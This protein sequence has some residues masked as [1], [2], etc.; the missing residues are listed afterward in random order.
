MDVAYFGLRERPF[1]SAADSRFIFLGA[2]QEKALAQ[3]LQGV[4]ERGGL[5]HLTG[6]AGLGKTTLCR[7]LLSRLPIGVDV[8]LVLNPVHSAED[9]LRAI[10]DE[11]G[12]LPAD[13]APA[14][15]DLAEV[16][17][18]HVLA[19]Q[20]N[21]RRVVLVVDDAQDL[22][23]G[24]LEELRRLTTLAA[25]TERLLQI[26]LIGRPELLELL[27]RSELQR[28]D[29]PAT[30][31]YDLLP[32]TERET[33]AYLRHRLTEAGGASE[34]FEREALAELHLRSGG[35]PRSINVLAERALHVAR[36]HGRRAVDRSMV[37]AAAKG[38]PVA[39]SPKPVVPAALPVRPG[40][41]ARTPARSSG[42]RALSPWL[43][44]A[45][46]V[47]NAIMLGM[48][49]LGWRPAGD[50]VAPLLSPTELEV[51]AV[52]A[53]PAVAQAPR[54]STPPA[55]PMTTPEAVSPAEPRRPEPLAPPPSS[56]RAI[57][58]E[59]VSAVP[60][61][62]PRRAR[63]TKGSLWNPFSPPVSN[64]P[65]P[66]EPVVEQPRLKVE[67]LV[68]AANPRDRW[69]YVNGRRYVEG[70]QLENG[71]VVERI[72]QDSVVLWQDGERVRLE[73]DAR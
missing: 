23:A 43:V 66:H 24:A 4:R 59:P 14:A 1:S 5:V 45:G 71:A 53:P 10:C 72:S 30:S 68:W 7:L 6:E 48:I 47:A 36:A 40:V 28:L 55:P 29:Q 31:G 67:M 39:P 54:A 49:V 17:Q 64:D 2:R 44:G 62:P 18:R 52:V 63:A 65:G 58:R 41:T 15:P 51:P 69:V 50:L 35:V 27:A 57:E 22:G 25:G 33:A 73:P 12:L 60:L 9:L 19:I 38:E 32:F 11:L 8:A 46:L 56:G 37:R 3:L 16:F 26:V 13:P 20:E 42:A 21:R 34:I 70:D 61:A